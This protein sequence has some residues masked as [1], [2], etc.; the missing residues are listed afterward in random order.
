MTA[1]MATPNS[2]RSLAPHNRPDTD[3]DGDVDEYD[4]D[5]ELEDT[6]LNLL[7]TDYA[8]Q[9]DLSCYPTPYQH[10]GR[11]NPSIPPSLRQSG[12]YA[13]GTEAYLEKPSSDTDEWEDESPIQ[14]D[15]FDKGSRY[16]SPEHNARAYQSY[17][18][19]RPLVDLIRN[20]WK[21]SPYTSSSSS[22]PNFHA[23]AV[24]SWLQILSAPRFR[25]YVL[26]AIGLFVL[27]W[28]NWHSWAGSQWEEHKLLGE[29]LKER[30]KTGDGWF[31][32]NMRPEF[33]DL[34]HVMTLDQELVPKGADHRRLIL[35]GDVHG[36][37][38]DCRSLDSDLTVPWLMRYLQWFISFQKFN[39]KPALIIS[40]S[41]AISL[42]RARPR[43]PSLIWPC[44]LT[45]RA[46]AATTKIVFFSP[47][48]TCSPTA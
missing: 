11:H 21:N 9:R 48:V 7:N 42:R 10:S 26:V 29:S 30:M 8:A 19:R 4:S 41:W 46:F 37:H 16:R 13:K 22:S 32:E 27:T 35:V 20:E 14:K 44:P 25:R 15:V 47:T 23:Y 33:L 38:D 2:A 5:E 40:S 28:G 39:T 6:D 36:C 31:G 45:P 1:L 17:H 34:V 12:T 18:Q 3:L 43:P 24:P